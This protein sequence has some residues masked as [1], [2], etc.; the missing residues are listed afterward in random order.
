MPE[1]LTLTDLPKFTGAEDPLVN[2]KA[3]KGQM[4]LKGVDPEYFDVVVP[5]SLAPNP[6]AWFYSLD[7]RKFKSFYEIAIAFTEQ[8]KDNVETKASIRT[9]DITIQ[10]EKEGFTEFLARWRAISTQL[11]NKP[12]EIDL[13]NKFIKNTRPILL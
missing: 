7:L 9:L 13:V 4:A 5:H 1:E 12:S 6:Q 10:G 2:I 8:Y 3:F 11:S